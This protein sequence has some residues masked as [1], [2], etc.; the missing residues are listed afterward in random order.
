MSDR[1]QARFA[2]S[3]WSGLSSLDI[4]I[5]PKDMGTARP[6]QSVEAIRNV[7]AQR[8]AVR[9]IAQLDA[10]LPYTLALLKGLR[11]RKFRLSC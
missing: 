4:D 1:G 2:R 6:Y 11:R 10:R 7:D 8:S 9:S 5:S 3:E